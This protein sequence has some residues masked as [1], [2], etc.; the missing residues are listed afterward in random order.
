MSSLVVTIKSARTGLDL[1]DRFNRPSSHPRAQVRQLIAHLEG[2]EGGCENISFDIQTGAADPVAASGTATLTYASIAAA[3]TV[4]VAGVVLTCVTGAPSGAQ[5]QKVTDGPTTAANLA[6][7]INSNATT[8]SYV[9]AVASGSVVTVK[10]LVKGPIGNLV[11]LASSNGV[12]VAVS[13][14]VLAG[15]AGGGLVAPTT[16]S[17]GL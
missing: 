6:A 16:Y 17:L 3:D 12:G 10:C 9:Y 5:W 1:A 11:T 2:A 15:G 13:G 8:S 14:A 4:T 7:L